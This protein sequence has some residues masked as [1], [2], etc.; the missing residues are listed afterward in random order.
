MA[1]EKRYDVD[2]VRRQKGLKSMVCAD[3]A[4]VSQAS[5]GGLTSVR[6]PGEHERL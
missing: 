5:G 1:E 3:M 6:G 2:G 4:E